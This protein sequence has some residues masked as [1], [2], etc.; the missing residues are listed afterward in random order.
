MSKK[1][2]VDVADSVWEAVKASDSGEAEGVGTVGIA[3]TEY[4][5][6]MESLWK[7]AIEIVGEI[8]DTWDW[9]STINTTSIT[10]AGTSEVE[11]EYSADAIEKEREKE[12]DML[13]SLV[14]FWNTGVPIDE[15]APLPKKR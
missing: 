8:Q 1:A 14:R 5:E 4:I 11:K 2:S 7:S 15:Q 13:T 9:Y 10:S 6:K 12:M 3:D